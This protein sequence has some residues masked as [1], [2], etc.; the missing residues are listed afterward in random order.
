MLEDFG[1]HLLA[2]R[3]TV[4]AWL[5][6]RLNNGA[7]LLLGRGEI[8][9]LMDDKSWLDSATTA[10]RA[11]AD[12]SANSPPPMSIQ[13]RGGAFHAKG[14]SLVLDRTYVA[15]KLNG[16]FPDNRR[17]SGLPTIQ[18][19]I[20]LCD[21]ENGKLLAVMDSVEVT[22]RRTA[23]ATALAARFLAR[24]DSSIV[25]LCG[26]GDQAHAQ[27]HALRSVLPLR[28]GFCWDAIPERAHAF[29][30]AESGDGLAMFATSDLH[31]AAS[32]SHVIIACTTA[33]I[34]FLTAQMVK[35][36]TF[37]AAVGADSP[38]KNEI[39]PELMASAMVVADSLSQC[40]Q[41]GD[42]HHAIDAKAMTKAKVYAELAELVA[43]SKRG[44]TD[45][46]GVTLFDSTGVAV[47]DVAAAVAVYERALLKGARSW[48]ALSR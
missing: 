13:A 47:Q 12:L 39:A 16:N 28:Q 20:L 33:T 19:A 25:T 26:C 17:N 23:A 44:R 11:V 6:P 24:K 4:T 15:L 3:R 42:L 31:G 9:S 2:F 7:T 32:Q 43:G 1:K 41:M 45:Q 30:R 38:Q 21:G 40:A 48:I 10:F 46:D 22:L 5:D 34:P 35:P 36:G 8:A 37:I 29:A 14:A 18:G 27:L